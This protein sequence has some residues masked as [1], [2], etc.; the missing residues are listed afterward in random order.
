MTEEEE[1]LSGQ[2]IRIGQEL[3]RFE[4]IVPP[5][6]IADGTE[7]MGSPNPGY[8]GKLTV[9]IGRNVDGS[10]FPL[11]GDSIT[12]GRERGEINFPDDGYVSGLHARVTNREELIADL[13]ALIANV[14]DGAMTRELAARQHLRSYK[15]EKSRH[16]GCLGYRLCEQHQALR[17]RA[18]RKERIGMSADVSMRVEEPTKLALSLIHI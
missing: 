1:L 9:I 4:L 15:Q 14:L 5:E 2:I 7:V 13:A 11:L 12:L 10:A 8:W 3:L 17:R 6:P 18:I 16:I